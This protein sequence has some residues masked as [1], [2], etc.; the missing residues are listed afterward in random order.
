MENENLFYDKMN[1]LTDKELLKVIKLKDEYNPDAAKAAEYVFEQRGLSKGIVE[2]INESLQAE[3]NN[4]Q[5]KIRKRNEKINKALSVA[6]VFSN[7]VT[8]D[9]DNKQLKGFKLFIIGLSIY[10]LYGIY[11]SYPY[12]E[13]ILMID[14]LSMLSMLIE[15]LLILV[16]Y[17]VGIFLLARL[18]KEG[19]LILFYFFMSKLIMIAAIFLVGVFFGLI[20]I[21]NP[22]PSSILNSIAHQPNWVNNVMILLTLG[23]VVWYLLKSSV[24]RLSNVNYK[25]KRS[26]IL[27]GIGVSI[28]YIA[29]YYSLFFLS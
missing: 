23:A 17:P 20:E 8:S 18:K 3:E 1:A 24:M 28:I 15:M 27:S 21:F 25:K 2:S 10:F 12:L 19:W 9:M 22:E 29:V 4:A 11:G 16:L 5:E 14:D 26:Y 7:G 13:F 6:S